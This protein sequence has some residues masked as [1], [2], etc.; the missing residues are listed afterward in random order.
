MNKKLLVIFGIVIVI[1][2]ITLLVGKAEQPEATTQA[3]LPVVFNSYSSVIYPVDGWVITKIWL[4]PGGVTYFELSNNGWVVN[5]MCTEPA[6]TPPPVGT[7]CTL[8]G[9]AFTC[10]GWQSSIII[11]ILTTPTPTATATNTPTPTATSTNTPTPTLTPIFTDTPTPTNTN[12]PTPTSCYNPCPAMKLRIENPAGNFLYNVQFLEAP[13]MN[14]GAEFRMYT[15]QD[16]K[17]S[18]PVNGP[19]SVKI[20]CQ[21]GTYNLTG[22]CGDG[23]CLFSCGDYGYS[24]TQCTGKV[25]ETIDTP[26]GQ[27]VCQAAFK[28][29]DPVDD[30]LAIRTVTP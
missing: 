8:N 20:T 17:M 11:K 13:G 12:T 29:I 14:T 3:F 9:D 10:P 28:V 6:I 25:V 16:A 2:A 7:V 22:K 30:M 1:L 21:S 27:V 4:G 18:F 24:L 26:C 5:A 19:A 15:G 23:S